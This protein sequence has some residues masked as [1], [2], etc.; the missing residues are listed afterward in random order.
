MTPEQHEAKKA[1][2]RAWFAKRYAEMMA[3][4]V[5]RAAEN[6][7]K[8]EWERRQKQKAEPAINQDVYRA[9]GPFAA[10]FCGQEAA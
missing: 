2:Q 5:Q 7:R 6:K 9:H 3:D 8:R 10:L 4:P 1:K